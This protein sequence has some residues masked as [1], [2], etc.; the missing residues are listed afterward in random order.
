VNT[1]ENS[2][3]RFEEDEFE[4]VEMMDNITI[5][6]AVIGG[7]GVVIK[8]ILDL[9]VNAIVNPMEAFDKQ[10]RT[11]EEAKRVKKATL[12]PQ[13]SSSAERIAAILNGERPATP[14]TLRGLVRE[15]A[16]N[17]TSKMERELQTL[18]AQMET[19]LSG[20]KRRRRSSLP[21]PSNRRRKATP[22]ILLQKTGKATARMAKPPPRRPSHPILQKQEEESPLQLSPTQ[23]KGQT[24]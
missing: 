6:P 12:K 2:G 14:A 8:A 10:V 9:V 1:P 19:L 11:Q 3:V 16:T 24:R 15:E 13:L 17:T 5:T 22:A 18:R 23:T 21:P 20:K 7:R 4:E